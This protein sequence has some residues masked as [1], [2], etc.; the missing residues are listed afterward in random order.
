MARAE[1]V[2]LVAGERLALPGTAEVQTQFEAELLQDGGVLPHI[3]L[4]ATRNKA[5]A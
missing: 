4:N 3:L 1:P 5:A 2:M